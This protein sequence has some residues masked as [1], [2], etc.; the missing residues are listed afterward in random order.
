MRIII[1]GGSGLIG[2]ALT[3]D[4]TAEGYEVVVLSRSPEK[5]KNLPTGATAHT[6]DGQSA[7]GWGHLADGAAA[8]V[9]LA[10]ENLAAGRWTTER[11]RII[12]DSRLNAGRAVVEAVEA[13]THKPEVVI[14]ASAVGYYGP[15]NEQGITEENPAGQDFVAQVCAEW[16]NSTAPV[17]AMGVRRVIIRTG[18]VLSTEGGALPRMLLPFKLFAGG[19]LGSG[20]QWLSWIHLADTVAA[21]RYLIE[22]PEASGPFNLTAPAPLTNATF[23]QTLGRVMHRPAIMPAPSFA[24]RLL[25]GE[26]ATVVLDGQ[27]ALPYRLQQ[28]GFTFQFPKAEAALQDLLS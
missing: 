5:M 22:Q 9:N 19:P 6:W 20:R 4:L 11:K 17:E 25:F 13:A 23:G 26:M 18:L 24:I 12:R 3:A 15:Q 28:L 7:A 27:Q 1:T 10:G 14:Q 2:R 16:E 8:I 21:I